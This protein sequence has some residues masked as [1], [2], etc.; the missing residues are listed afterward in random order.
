MPADGSDAL[1]SEEPAEIRI[2]YRAWRDQG[3][4]HA[5]V[6]V[7]RAD[8]LICCTMRTSLDGKPIHLRRGTGIVRVYLDR[9]AAG[10]RNV[11]G[12]NR[13]P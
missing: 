11:F 7:N 3:D 2:E 5:A 12:G 1:R 10:F 13:L 6:F 4:V 9:A 8:G